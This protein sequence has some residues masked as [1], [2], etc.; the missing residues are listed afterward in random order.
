MTNQLHYR[1]IFSSILK[2]EHFDFNFSKIISINRL[3]DSYLII[4]I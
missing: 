4:Y 1:I 2:N 3:I